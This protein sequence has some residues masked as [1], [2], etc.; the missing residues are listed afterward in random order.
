MSVSLLRCRLAGRFRPDILTGERCPRAHSVEGLVLA[1]LAM[2]APRAGRC[3][4]LRVTPLLP[5]PPFRPTADWRCR[6]G[7]RQM[8]DARRAASNKEQ[9]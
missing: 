9:R 8:F 3:A 1:I 4:W 7:E 6:D 2:L 5:S